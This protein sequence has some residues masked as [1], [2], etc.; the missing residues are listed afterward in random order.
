MRKIILVT[1]GETEKDTPDPCFNE[2]GKRQM[3]EIKPF[4]QK[5]DYN[6]VVLGIG[7]RHRE[8]CDIIIGRDRKI[9]FRSE[10]AGVSETLSSDGSSMIFADGT[11]ISI[12]EYER[13]RYRKLLQRIPIFLKKILTAK[14]I[15][16]DVLIIGSRITAIGAGIAPQSVKSGHIYSIQ[17]TST[18]KISI[19]DYFSEK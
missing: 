2:R 5:L 19:N 3:E 9:D 14:S 16:G 18:G 4:V 7:K 1:H 8:A 15:Q 11:R 13:T 6:F 12:R 17:L 10:L